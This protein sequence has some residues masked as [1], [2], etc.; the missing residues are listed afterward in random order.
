[1]LE[2]ALRVE[3]RGLSPGALGRWEDR[4]A[5][6]AIRRF[7]ADGN[8]RPIPN[9]AAAWRLQPWNE[10]IEY[11]LDVNG[12]RAP[13][14]RI[15]AD[16]CRAVAL[17]DSQTFG[18]G[19]RGRHA[20]PTAVTSLFAAG[21]APL[22]VTNAGICGSTVAAQ[23]AWLPAAL[24]VVRPH[25]VVVA[26]TPWSLRL[27]PDPPARHRGPMERRLGT[28]WRRLEHRS[29]V[30]ERASRLAARHLTRWIGWPAPSEVLWE[31]QPLTEPM[32]SFRRRWRGVDSVL[33]GM[34]RQ[35]RLAGAEPLLLYL[36]L[37]LQLSRGRNRLY[38]EGRLPYPTHG[39][40]DVDYTSDARYERGLTKTMRRLRVRHV[41]AGAMLRHVAA[42][43]FL[44]DAYHLSPI[45][46]AH[47]AALVAPWLIAACEERPTQVD[48]SL[49]PAPY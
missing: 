34:V 43:A 11:R 45:G 27:D 37:D 25:V 17:G 33:A 18:Y 46:H 22:S 35:V 16:G 21:G 31:L 44:P 42:Q 47:V 26:V 5:W 39:F 8:P 38:R 23:A 15:V 40:A 14:P 20:W 3:A 12:F 41:H 6:E 19:V 2:I 10:T 13:A 1:M 32:A 7:T 36:P 48:A 9:G 29:A 4:Q 24:D 28:Y 30:V 49:P